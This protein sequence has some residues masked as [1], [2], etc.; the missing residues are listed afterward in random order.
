MGYLSAQII[1]IASKSDGE[2]SIWMQMLV[3][4]ILAVSYGVYSLVRT[5]AKESGEGGQYY[6]SGSG[7]GGGRVRRQIGRFKELKRRGVDVFLKA[8]RPKAVTEGTVLDFDGGEMGAKDE[9]GTERGR[10]LASGMEIL[11]LDFLV[12][13][14]ED[15]KGDDD[16]DVT[17]RQFSFNELVRRGRLKAAESSALKVYAVNEGNL[18]GK[19]VQCKAMKELAERTSVRSGRQSIAHL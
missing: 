14:V 11:E 7:R 9:L 6:P 2:D 17:I 4:V 3:F 12:G 8:V 1:L 19:D 16:T 18:Y 5:K 13:I 15:T 10:D